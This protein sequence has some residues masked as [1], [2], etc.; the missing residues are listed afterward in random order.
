MVSGPWSVVSSSF[1]VVWC[2]FVDR[3]SDYQHKTIREITRTD[4]NH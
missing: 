4:T 3:I 1:R 2:D